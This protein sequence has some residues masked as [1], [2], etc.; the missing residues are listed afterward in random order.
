MIDYTLKK[1]KECDEVEKYSICISTSLFQMNSP[2]RDFTKYIKRFRE[3]VKVIPKDAYVRMYVDASV[4]THNDFI[5]IMTMKKLEVIL[6]EFPDFLNTTLS[7]ANAPG[8]LKDLYYHDGTFG[9]MTRFLAFYHK[10]GFHKNLKYIWVCDM[11]SKNYNF[12]YQDI[13][14]MKKYKADILH[15]SFACY[16]HT[17][18]DDDVKYPII[19]SKIIINSKV[20]LP[21]NEYSKFLEGIIEGKYIKEKEDIFR[22]LARSSYKKIVETD[23]IKYFPYGFDELFVNRYMEKSFQKYSRI[24]YYDIRLI[25]FRYLNKEDKDFA[26]LEELSHEFMYGNL[27]KKL[28]DKFLAVNERIYNRYKDREDIYGR[29][30]VCMNDFNEYKNKANHP[31]I[32]DT[33]F[34]VIIKV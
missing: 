1:I 23:S 32:P 15:L 3:W 6:Y 29:R 10:P 34:G 22:T 33:S 16:P 14:N 4:I 11:D 7:R 2:Y 19:A 9:T 8:S 26:L 20:R 24:I 5:K 28:R 17:W 27:S 13:L 18:I 30:K 25:N 21:F 31:I 12:S